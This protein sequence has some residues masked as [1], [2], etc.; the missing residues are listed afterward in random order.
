MY[1]CTQFSNR[2]YGIFDSFSTAR[3]AEI[4]RWRNVLAGGAEI[5]RAE[6]FRDEIFRRRNFSQLR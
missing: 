2:I 3:G 4:F 6:I 5:F 1:L